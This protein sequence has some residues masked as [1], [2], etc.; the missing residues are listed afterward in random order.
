MAMTARIFDIMDKLS[1]ERKDVIYRLAIDM[2]SAQEI[3]S[4]D[5]YSH[6]EIQEIKKARKRVATGDCLTFT[7]A[8]DF[9]AHFS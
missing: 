6:D 1:D 7:S 2:L 5:D 8:E 3:E 9:K 4:F